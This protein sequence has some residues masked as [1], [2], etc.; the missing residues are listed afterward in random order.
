MRTNKCTAPQF[1]DIP[2]KSRGQQVP[3][4]I[5]HGML[6]VQFD[7]EP[8]RIILFRGRRGGG[9]GLCAKCNG[10]VIDART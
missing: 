9:S 1:L 8:G 7:T 10:V 3:V 6:Q 5:E 2:P 4:V